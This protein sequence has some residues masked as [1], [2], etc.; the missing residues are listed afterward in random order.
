MRMDERGSAQPGKQRVGFALGL[1]A[2]C[3]CV[4]APVPAITEN[5]TYRM[6]K[7]VEPGGLCCSAG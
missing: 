1:P 6:V 7:I 5:G 2:G 4:C 3:G